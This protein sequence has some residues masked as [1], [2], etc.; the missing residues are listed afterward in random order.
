MLSYIAGLQNESIVEITAKVLAPK[1]KIESCSQKDVELEILTIRAVSRSK[2]LLPFQ[3]V[4]ACRK[5]NKADLDKAEDDAEETKGEGEN[6]EIKVHMKTRLDN[7]ILDLRTPAKQA[8]FQI[9][10]MVCQ[11]FRE[12]LYK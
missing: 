6:K 3:M 7:R 12:F 10:S 2:A 11:L 8:I 1:E 5:V 9:N 4:D